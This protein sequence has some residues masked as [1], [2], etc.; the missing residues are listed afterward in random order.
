[1]ENQFQNQ[2]KRRKRVWLWL[3]L[4]PIVAFL[5]FF[6]FKTSF[7]ISQMIDFRQMFGWTARVL[8]F[9]G[10]DSSQLPKKDPDRINVLLLGMRGLEDPGEGKLLSDAIILV[11]INKKTGQIALISL[12]RD[13][14]Y[15]IWCSG[16]DKKINFAYAHGGLDCAKKTIASLTGLYIDYTVSANFEGLTGAIDA[17]GGITIY[18]EEP[19]EEDFQWAKEGQEE[20]EHWLIKEIDGEERWVFHLP[21]GQ[22]V[23][24]GQTALYYARS[25]YSTDD[26]DRMRRQQKVLL[27]IKEKALSLGVLIN[28]IKVYQLLD[29]L[30]ENIRTDMSLANIK[31]LVESA[32]NLDTQNIKRRIF[33]TSPE[34][35]LYHT[36][37]NDEYILLPVGDNFGQIRDACRNIF[38]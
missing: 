6:F 19:F 23:L 8:P 34:G 28:P 16:E 12:P 29:T 26:F 32:D 18:L 11:S 9:G 33:D 30:G 21:A 24:D 4:F 2:P 31:E 5:G 17:L 13:I 36:F 1:M 35:L 22:N 25:R 20:G 37:I 27:A 14:Y 3:C 38:D 10:D 7:T 15:K